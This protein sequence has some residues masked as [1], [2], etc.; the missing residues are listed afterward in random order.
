M[1]ILAGGFSGRSWRVLESLPPNFKDQFERNL[2]R[3]GFRPI[4]VEKGEVQ[5]AGWVNIRQMLDARLTMDKVLFGDLIALGLRVD[6]LALNQKLFRATLA[7]E[8]GRK[9]RQTGREGLGREQR[10]VLEDKVRLELLRRTAP[11][12]A[13]HEMVWHLPSGMVLLGSGAR[14]VGLLFADLFAETFQVSIKPQLPFLRAQDWA[15]RNGAERRLLELLP[16]PFSP[17]APLEVVEVRE[18]QATQ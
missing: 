10:V 3:H 15:E 7:Q 11:A 2:G 4:D 16:S 14:K 17:E 8:I 13:L 9:L 5:S 6:R 1:A 12:T 18:E